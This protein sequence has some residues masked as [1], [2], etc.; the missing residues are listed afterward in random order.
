[1]TILLILLILHGTFLALA[2]AWRHAANPGNDQLALLVSTVVTILVYALGASA[3]VMP[4][5]MAAPAW[6]LIGPLTLSYINRVTGRRSCV[7]RW[8]AAVGVLGTTLA[9]LPLYSYTLAGGPAV[10]MSVQIFVVYCG[11]WI[12]T[13]SC[14]AAA[15]A[16]LRSAAEQL[17]NSPIREW[18]RRWLSALAILLVCYTLFDLSL[19]GYFLLRGGYP[20]QAGVISLT[21]LTAIIYTIALPVVA[22]RGLL[23][24][25]PGLQR[26]YQRAELS[27]SV[28]DALE[29]RLRA[30]M[31]RDRLW[32]SEGLD[33][34]ALAK[35]MEIAPHQLSQLLNVHMGTNFA[36]FLNRYRV[37]DA[38]RLLRELHSQRSVLD[39]AMDAGFASS[40]TFYRAFKKHFG[41]TPREY[42][43]RPDDALTARSIGR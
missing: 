35:R 5:L 38:A 13:G 3:G 24:S 32:R 43:T 6:F 27:N 41:M 34:G 20:A 9:L 23:Q 15:F 14:A 21:L 39:I 22:P 30:L 1:M 19:T 16:G 10:E 36:D 40:A 7:P 18:Q 17:A 4:A 26:S 42:L 29:D 31:V 33:H 12:C 8:I 37:E 11:F 2:L 28:A 25:V